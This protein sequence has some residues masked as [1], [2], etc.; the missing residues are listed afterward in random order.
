[1]MEVIGLMV[2]VVLWGG[3]GDNGGG[4]VDG[5]GEGV[6]VEVVVLMGWY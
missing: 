4:G 2:V 3:A 1:M 5:R 6:M